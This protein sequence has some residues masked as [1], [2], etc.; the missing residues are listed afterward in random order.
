MLRAAMAAAAFLCISSMLIL[1]LTVALALVTFLVTE[2]GATFEAVCDVFTVLL[3]ATL[4][5]VFFTSG[6][7]EVVGFVDFAGVLLVLTLVPT[8]APVG[9][10]AAGVAGFCM[11]VS[12]DE[13]VILSMLSLTGTG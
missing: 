7:A 2:M 6:E 1:L 9:V 5:P 12:A 10:G 8:V 11:G 4:V 3:T 13:T